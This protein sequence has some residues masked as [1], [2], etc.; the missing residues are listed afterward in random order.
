MVAKPEDR[1]SAVRQLWEK[2][3]AKLLAFYI[4]FGEYDWLVVSEGEQENVTAALVAAAAGGSITD[5]KTMAAMTASALKEFDAALGIDLDNRG[6]NPADWTFYRMTDEKAKEVAA[7]GIM[8]AYRVIQAAAGSASAILDASIW[9]SDK[10]K[11]KAAGKVTDD[12]QPVRSFHTLMADLGA[13]CLNEVAAAPNPNYVLTM[14]TRPTAIQQKAL[15]LLG[16][17]LT[18]A[19]WSL[20]PVTAPWRG[21]YLRKINEM[22]IQQVKSSV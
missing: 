12:D 5:M 11:A 14:T 3:G 4:T 21:Q 1:E 15:E 9:S 20:Y 18:T 13:L 22:R 7:G 16:A 19:Q 17:S 6:L 2:A 8:T 10:A